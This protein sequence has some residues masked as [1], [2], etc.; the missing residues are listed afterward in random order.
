M[1]NQRESILKS[2]EEGVKQMAEAGISILAHYHSLADKGQMSE[3]EARDR[4]KNDLRDI[5]FDH[6]NFLVV[7]RMDGVNEVLPPEPKLEGQQMIDRKDPNG[8]PIV[9]QDIEIAKA[10]GGFGA[11]SSP[12]RAGEPPVPKISAILPFAPWDMLVVCGVFI[13]DID[14]SFHQQISHYGLILGLSTLGVLALSLF[15]VN[16]ITAP[17]GLITQRMVNLSQGDKSIA[18][19]FTARRDEIGKLAKALEIFRTNAIA[20]DAQE[21]ARRTAEQVAQE[22]LRQEKT[23]IADRFEQ[24]VMG[25]IQQGSTAT[26]DMERTAQ[27]MNSVADSARAQA[28]SAANAAQQATSNVQTVAAASEELYAS[29]TE[30]SRQVGEAA[31]ISTE[32]SG[33]TQRIDDMMLSLSAAAQRIGEVVKLVNDIAG[34]TNLLALNATIEAARA[35]EAGKGFTVVAGEVKTLAAQTARATDEIGTQIAA[36]QSETNRAVDA[37]KGITATINQIQQISSGIASAVEQQGAA[38]QEIAR[39]VS[40]AAQGNQE[41]SA[42]IAGLNEAAGMTGLVAGEVFAAAQDINKNNLRLRQEIE[43]FISGVRSS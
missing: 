9:R 30:I 24:S 36:V 34:Q 35:G 13:D 42:N 26:D 8:V 23:A 6:G 37:I 17:L 12:R 25:L 4:A 3:S 31:R 5:R 14:A 43:Q 10:G 32:A 33:E 28:Q 38:T 11:Y 20:L 19:G 21:E 1:I 2:R 7:Y 15:L 39:N 41:V 40:Q 27:S 16:S 18:I 29:I 22:A